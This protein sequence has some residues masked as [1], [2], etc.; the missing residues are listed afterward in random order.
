VAAA[1][2]GERKIA[3]PRAAAARG[4]AV[5]DEA[6]DQAPAVAYA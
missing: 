5:E 4:P 6:E 2:G 3:P 1:G